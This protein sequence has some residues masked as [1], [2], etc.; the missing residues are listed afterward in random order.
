MVIPKSYALTRVAVFPADEQGRAQ[1][2]E[3]H[4]LNNVLQ[5]SAGEYVN[6]MKRYPAVWILYQPGEQLTDNGGT[7]DNSKRP[8]KARNNKAKLQ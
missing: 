5:I 8:D 6:N 7:D 3:F 2:A 4:Q 1:L